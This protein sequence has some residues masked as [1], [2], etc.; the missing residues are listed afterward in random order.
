M[1]YQHQFIEWNCDDVSKLNCSINS[2]EI[3]NWALMQKFQ[4]TSAPRKCGIPLTF[5]FLANIFL[6]NDLF[7]IE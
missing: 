4:I 5:V 6:L 1:E 2:E 7:A 3:E